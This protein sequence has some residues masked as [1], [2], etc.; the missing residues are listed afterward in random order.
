MERQRSL[1]D[2]R[3]S[4]GLTQKELG[5][6]LG[7]SDRTIFGYEKDSSNIPNELLR[8]Y[9]IVFNVSYD[10]IFLGKEYDKNELRKKALLQRARQLVKL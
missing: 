3:N 4:C 9:M 1:L 5:E 6:I 8:K 2:L 7:V 10:D